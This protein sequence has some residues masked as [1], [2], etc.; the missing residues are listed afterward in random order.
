MLCN[1]EVIGVGDAD[2]DI[3][4]R[5]DHVPTR[6]D[7]VRASHVEFHPGG[8]V[9]NFVCALSRLGTSCAFHGPVGSDEFGQAAVDNLIA[10][11]VDTSG[12]VVKAGGKTYLG[13]AMLDASGEKAALGIPSECMHLEPAELS[14]LQIAR[15]CHLHTV[16]W[17]P[18]TLRAAQLA[19]ELHLT[20]SVDLESPYPLKLE[21]LGP[22]LSLADILL[23]NRRTLESFEGHPQ[24]EDVLATMIEG[25]TRMVCVTMGQEGAVAASGIARVKVDAFEVPVADTTGAGDCFAAGFVHGFL[26]GWALSYMTLFASATAAIAVT[27]W[28]G[29]TG[30][31]TQEEVVRFLA[32]RGI[33]PP[34]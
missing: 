18:T 7:K 25:G 15:A 2:M 1:V 31:P 33:Q 23:L 14:Q 27:C 22:L 4:A 28:G 16:G 24:L 6:D 13:V 9:A 8:M 19:K 3:F 32:A 34:G 10:H 21:E 17:R 30:A 29:H 12:V 26:K 5:V 11:G 20:V